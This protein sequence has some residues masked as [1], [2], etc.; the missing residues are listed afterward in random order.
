MYGWLIFV[1]IPDTGRIHVLWRE[2]WCPIIMD[3]THH[4]PLPFTRFPYKSGPHGH[5]QATIYR[6]G[7]IEPRKSLLWTVLRVPYS[8]YEWEQ[9]RKTQCCLY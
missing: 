8:V 9:E 5:L 7:H 2:E 1:F 3:C 6:D 4:A